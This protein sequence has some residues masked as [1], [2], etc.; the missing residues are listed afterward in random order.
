[1]RE[2]Q[3][4][5]KRDKGGSTSRIWRSKEGKSFSKKTIIKA[6]GEVLGQ[7]LHEVVNDLMPL[8]RLIEVGRMSCVGQLLRLCGGRDLFEVL[9][10][11]PSEAVVVLAVNDLK[12][13][14][15]STSLMRTTLLNNR[16]VIQSIVI[17]STPVR[18][19]SRSRRKRSE[20]F[21]WS[22][23]WMRTTLLNN[24]WVIQSIVI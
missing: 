12:I 7:S 23:S 3:R 20:K 1:M 19:R 14:N 22:T 21:N 15:W 16:C 6:I 4:N 2:I 10:R 9:L 17:S 5:L 8:G 13:F 24:R 11:L 18:G